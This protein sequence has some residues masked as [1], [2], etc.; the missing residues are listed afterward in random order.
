MYINFSI[1]TYIHRYGNDNVDS[2][3][4]YIHMY[5]YTYIGKYIK[6]LAYVT[7]ETVTQTHNQSSPYK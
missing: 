4:L 6:F 1:C 3:L 2:V 5:I 7:N